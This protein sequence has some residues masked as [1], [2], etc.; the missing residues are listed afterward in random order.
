MNANTG[1]T[2]YLIAAAGWKTKFFKENPMKSF[3]LPLMAL[4][5]VLSLAA[6][7]LPVPAPVPTVTPPVTLPAP[8]TVTPAP[9]FTQVVLVAVPYSESGVAPN[10]TITTSTPALQ[11]SSDP[12]VLAFN[13]AMTDLV[14]QEIA[15]FKQDVASLPAEPIG[16]GSFLEITFEQLAPTGNL[17]SIK[18]TIQFY[19][20]GAAHPN[21]YSRTATY[22]LEAGSFLTLDRLFLPGADY[23][24]AISAYCK[25]ELATRDIDY[26]LTSSAGA[27]PLPENYRNWNVTAD[28]L[29]I[30]FDPYQVASY[31][32]G[33][34]LITIPY[35]D[36]GAI[37]DPHGP[38]D[39]LLP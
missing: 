5:V 11:G 20:D 10:Y 30:T 35:A 2:N 39:Y 18:F 17:L 9:L 7:N 22:D 38:L 33:P 25:T 26:D 34:Q 31:A 29:L 19:S 21:T 8:P 4:A 28:G 15:A 27:D 37:L 14:Q 13:Q 23:L 12:R 32:A 6:C 24:D 3:F 16:G 36:L 1:M